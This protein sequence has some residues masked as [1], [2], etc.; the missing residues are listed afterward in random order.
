[1]VE[2][3]G[4]L[5]VSRTAPGRGAWLCRGS[6]QCVDLAVRRDAFSRALRVSVPAAVLQH[7]ASQLVE[8]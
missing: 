6:A 4:S 5:V 1:M 8:H 3:A 2:A 7:L